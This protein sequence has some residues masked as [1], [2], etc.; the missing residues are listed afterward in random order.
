MLDE[1]TQGNSRTETTSIELSE[2]LGFEWLWCLLFCNSWRLS[3]LATRIDKS[4]SVNFLIF[5]CPE[6][7]LVPWCLMLKL[8]FMSHVLNIAPAI[9]RFAGWNASSL[10]CI[11]S[12]IEIRKNHENKKIAMFF[13][14]PNLMLFVFVVAHLP[15]TCFLVQCC[16]RALSTFLI[17]L[18]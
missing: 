3:I 14:H 8:P 16:L 15:S 5:Y 2:E 10:T 11:S 1:S 9:C 6:N 13:G 12:N 18:L 17:H 4:V 7:C